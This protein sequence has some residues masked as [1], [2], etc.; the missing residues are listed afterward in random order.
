MSQ[1]N[2]RERFTDVLVEEIRAL[3][4]R[5]GG[6]TESEMR[7]TMR[8]ACK[9]YDGTVSEFRKRHG[10]TVTFGRPSDVAHRFFA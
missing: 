7:E 10:L 3:E 5:F 4:E 1:I 9:E 6:L 2:Y 8:V